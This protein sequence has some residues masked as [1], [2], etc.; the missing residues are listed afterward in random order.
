[1]YNK[2]GKEVFKEDSVDR[3]KIFANLAVQ[4]GRAVVVEHKGSKY[5]VN[6]KNEIISGTTGKIMQWG[7]ENGDRKAILAQVSGL[8]LST[9]TQ[10]KSS[11]QEPENPFCGPN[12]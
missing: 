2:E 10:E 3:N 9:P 6:T 7:E 8:K 11:N 5:I 12:Q 1:M 4:E